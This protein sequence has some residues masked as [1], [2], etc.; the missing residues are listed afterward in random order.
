[1]PRSGGSVRRSLRPVSII[2]AL[3]SQ[4]STHTYWHLTGDILATCL[5]SVRQQ[6]SRLQRP[7]IPMTTGAKCQTCPCLLAHQ[8][9]FRMSRVDQRR[10][11]HR[12][13]PNRNIVN[14]ANLSYTDPDLS[15]KNFMHPAAGRAPQYRSV[16]R[17]DLLRVPVG[18][19]R[20]CSQPLSGQ[21]NSMVPWFGNAVHMPEHLCRRSPPAVLFLAGAVSPLRRRVRRQRC[22]SCHTRT[23]PMQLSPPMICLRGTC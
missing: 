7:S 8:L 10:I 4:C 9:E 22:P 16:C 17:R 19:S 15:R 21:R 3:S 12:S 23:G 14:M 20:S 18:C 5:Q 2:C 1:M 13:S 6:A 11:S